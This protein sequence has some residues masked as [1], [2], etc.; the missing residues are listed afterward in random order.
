MCDSEYMFM[1]RGWICVY[2]SIFMCV[3]VCV[4]EYV[5]ACVKTKDLGT[6]GGLA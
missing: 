5:Y 2:A 4:R 1:L 3:C 6:W